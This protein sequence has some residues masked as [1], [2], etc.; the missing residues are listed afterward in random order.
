V[1]EEKEKA[2]VVEVR[3]AIEVSEAVPEV[4]EEG[5]A[6]PD[7][8]AASDNWANPMDGGLARKTE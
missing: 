8:P 7:P 3:G 2:P 1:S 6:V 5:F 4:G